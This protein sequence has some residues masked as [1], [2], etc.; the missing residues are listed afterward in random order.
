MSAAER[1]SRHL[2][3]LR[4]PAHGA[5]YLL[6]ERDGRIVGM[7][8]AGPSRD[9]DADAESTGEIYALYAAPG[10][11]STGVGSALMTALVE[12]LRIAGFRRL[13]LWVLADNRRGRTFYERWGM[14]PDGSTKV[15]D[16]GAPV[17]EVR[18]VLDLC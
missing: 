6:A 10:A 7:A 14:R 5:S 17:E 13:T 15:L 1:E 9:D 3:R 12:A 4:D 2:A 8:S 16:L 11:W 18:Y